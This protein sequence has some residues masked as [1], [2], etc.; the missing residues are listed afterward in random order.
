LVNTE[1]HAV[2]FVTLGLFVLD[3]LS[4]L[5]DIVHSFSFWLLFFFNFNN[6][7]GI[8]EFT[9]PYLLFV[10]ISFTF[11]NFTEVIEASLTRLTQNWI[12]SG[13]LRLVS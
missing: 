10:S 12:T 3:L 13:K 5:D 6:I 8:A 2:F 1:N 11:F 4:C 7:L 9:L